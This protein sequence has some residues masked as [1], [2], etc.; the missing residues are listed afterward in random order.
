MGECAVQTQQAAADMSVIQV[1]LACRIAFCS[2]HNC[3]ITDRP[4][5]PREPDTGWTTNFRQEIAAIDTAIN[6]LT[7]ELSTCLECGDG[8]TRLQ[9]LPTSD[10]STPAAAPACSGKPCGGCL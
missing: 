8:R 9:S 3:L 10:P 1:L 7:G 2:H 6:K 5:L 4:D